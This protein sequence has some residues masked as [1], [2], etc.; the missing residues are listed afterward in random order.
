MANQPSDHLRRLV[1][2]V[3]REVSLQ[4]LQQMSI[5]DMTIAQHVLMRQMEID[6]HRLIAEATQMQCLDASTRHSMRRNCLLDIFG[7]VRTLLNISG[8]IYFQETCQ[9]FTPL[10]ANQPPFRKYLNKR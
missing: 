4:Q 8:A 5:A 1:T 3:F 2:L 6:V 9:T 7:N 10:S